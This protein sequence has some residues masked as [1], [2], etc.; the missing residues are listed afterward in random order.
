MQIAKNFLILRGIKA[1]G[2]ISLALERKPI[3]VATLLDEE[4]F[5]HNGHGLLH[6]RTVFLE[7]QMHDWAWENG[8][9]R[10][11][12]R[13]A[14]VADVLIVYEVGDVFFCPQCGTKKEVLDTLCGNCGHNPDA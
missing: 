4:Q 1:D 11:F 3:K 9:F 6:N 2:R 13:V 12:S 7:D 10:Y 8:R 14:G 5:N